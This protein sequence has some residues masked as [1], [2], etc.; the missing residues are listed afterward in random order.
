MGTAT[1]V[2][3]APATSVEPNSS[4]AK[5]IGA[6]GL[7]AIV[8]AGGEGI[9]LRPLT[10]IACGDE[11]PKQY[12]ALVDSRSLLRHTLDRVALG[13]PAE[14]TVVVTKR[15]HSKYMPADLQGTPPFVLVQPEDRGTAAGVL[16][17]TQW[18][19]WRDPDA[20][21][22]VFPSDH[23]VTDEGAFMAHVSGV[24]SFVAEHPHLCVLLGVPPT[25][26]DSGYGWIRPG[27]RL[28]TVGGEPVHRVHQFWEKPSEYGA[29]AA[30]ASG[31]LWNT[32][33]VVARAST[34]LA[35]GRQL[36]P[37]LAQ[38][39]AVLE[40]FFGTTDE[41][42]AMHQAFALAPRADFSRAIL[43]VSSRFLA[44][45]R[46]PHVGWSD[47]GTPERVIQTLSAAGISPPWLRAVVAATS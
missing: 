4:S 24:A 21:V 11:R 9:R 15:Q 6:R 14:R 30:Y 27:A 41:E 1:S 5:P 29:Q 25:S 8:L 38:R 7:W 34:L 17:P 35:A 26:A 31:Y 42:W 28:G 45:A 2:A 43:E 33:I 44:V 39:L 20:I 47:W 36:V 16:L 18:I 10:R 23:Y 19:H 22:T 3:D 32:F 46:L 37:K 40:P 12:A 13:I